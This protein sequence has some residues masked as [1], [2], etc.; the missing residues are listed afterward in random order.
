MLGIILL[1]TCQWRSYIIKK[2]HAICPEVCSIC[3]LGDE[4]IDEIF[5]SDKAQGIACYTIC[6][7]LFTNNDDPITYGR[8]QVSNHS[9]KRG[10]FNEKKEEGKCNQ[11]R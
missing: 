6:L 11:N 1:V 3:G 9:R 7:E 4:F 5:L 2:N 10:I 8:T